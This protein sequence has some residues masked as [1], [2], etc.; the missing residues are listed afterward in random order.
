M[1]IK[2]W[3][4]FIHSQHLTCSYGFIKQTQLQGFKH[5]NTYLERSLSRNQLCCCNVPPNHRPVCSSVSQQHCHP[6]AGHDST[7][8]KGKLVGSHIAKDTQLSQANV[9]GFIRLQGKT[10]QPMGFTG[11][12]ARPSHNW[13]SHTEHG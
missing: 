1:I 7:R 13:V 6:Q 9:V 4:N 5:K 10:F 12:S 8:N 11:H 2:K 3:S